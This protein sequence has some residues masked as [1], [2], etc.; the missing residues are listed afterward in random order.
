MR[1]LSVHSQAK[2]LS[3]ALA[4]NIAAD[5]QQLIVLLVSGEL[6]D[7]YDVFVVPVDCVLYIRF[8]CNSLLLWS[9]LVHQ[10]YFSL[11]LMVNLQ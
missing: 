8:L 7:F 6:Y 9:I 4:H 1:N 10:R 2:A 3:S 5:K 11:A